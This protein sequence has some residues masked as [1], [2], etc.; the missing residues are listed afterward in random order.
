M[1]GVVVLLLFAAIVGAVTTGVAMWLQIRYNAE[2]RNATSANLTKQLTDEGAGDH[3]EDRR[4]IICV[5][6]NHS[7]VLPNIITKTI[8]MGYEYGIGPTWI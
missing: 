3:A 2:K 6:S 7:I 4:P 8:N 1:A 5:T